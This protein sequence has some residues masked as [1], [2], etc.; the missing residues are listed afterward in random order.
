MYNLAS[1]CSVNKV[2]LRVQGA[3]PVHVAAALELI[4]NEDEKEEE[5]KKRRESEN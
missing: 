4:D 1:F 5:E 2:T 3:V